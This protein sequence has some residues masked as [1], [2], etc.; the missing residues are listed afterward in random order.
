MAESVAERRA[1]HVGF[2]GS[3]ST[4]VILAMHL[5]QKLPKLTETHQSCQKYQWIN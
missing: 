2:L 3:V 4:Q 1:V 5:T